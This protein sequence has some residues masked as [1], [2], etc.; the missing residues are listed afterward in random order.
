MW[1]GY[2]SSR[3]ALKGYERQ[4]NSHLQICKQLLA[5]A[6]DPE[7]NARVEFLRRAMAV[8]QHHDGV[9]GTEKQGTSM[10]GTCWDRAKQRD[11]RTR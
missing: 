9:S 1:T 8:L 3:A 7:D 10:S 6:G 4:S 11:S 5:L 2:F